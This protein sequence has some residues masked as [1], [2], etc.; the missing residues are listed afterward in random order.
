M[1]REL[2]E[3]LEEG[4]PRSWF[5]PEVTVNAIE[6]KGSFPTTELVVEFTAPSRFGDCRFLYSDEPWSDPDVMELFEDYFGEEYA[7]L[8]RQTLSDDELR[9]CASGAPLS[10]ADMRRSRYSN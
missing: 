3:R 9:R 2:V 6:L 7:W 4:L 10:I 1:E 8:Q 5:S